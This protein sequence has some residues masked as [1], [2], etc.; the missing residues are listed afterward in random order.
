MFLI[1][2]II[3]NKEKIKRYGFEKTTAVDLAL[4]NLFIT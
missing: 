4:F 1:E 3:I 2:I